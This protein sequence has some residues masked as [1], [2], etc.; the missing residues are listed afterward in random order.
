ML[1]VHDNMDKI[2]ADEGIERKETAM[3]SNREGGYM[4]HG[5]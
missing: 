5:G 4:W 2:P 1:R 3:E